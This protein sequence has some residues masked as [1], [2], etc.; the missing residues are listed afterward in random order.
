MNKAEQEKFHRCYPVLAELPPPLLARVEKEARLV[1][2]SAGT[3]LFQEGSPCMACPLLIEGT[4]RASKSDPDGHEI[5]LYRLVPGE[6]CVI[7]AVALLGETPYPA[8]GKAETDLTFFA[9]P[10]ELFQDLV[11]N[12]RPFRTFVFRFLS[13]RM[14]H[15]MALL[16]D[17]AFRRVDQRLASH[18]LHHDQPI[19]ETHQMLADSLG[20]TR[21]VVSRILESF[22]ESG[23]L[24]LGRKRIEIL[25]RTALEQLH[26]AQ[27]SQR[28]S[29]R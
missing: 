24:R 8:R 27:G 26:R 4:L 15:L 12:S 23:M 5:L 25:D 10:R 3:E 2:V 21:E 6:T 18:L 14:A 11:L 13:I 17:V 16:D 22:Q 29:S 19:S 1:K 7:T 9:L 28:I 20:T